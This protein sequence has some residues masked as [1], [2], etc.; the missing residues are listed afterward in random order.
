MNDKA[1]FRDQKLVQVTLFGSADAY[2]ARD[3]VQVSLLFIESL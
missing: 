3:C 2:K 1:A